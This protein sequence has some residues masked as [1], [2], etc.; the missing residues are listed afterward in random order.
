VVWVGVTIGCVVNIEAK[1][2]WELHAVPVGVTRT[3]VSELTWSP[4]ERVIKSEEESD[5]TV[6]SGGIESDL[7]V[8]LAGAAVFL[9]RATDGKKERERE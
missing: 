7:T 6:S 5:L 4:S 9:E 1:M 2:N 3:R 8:S